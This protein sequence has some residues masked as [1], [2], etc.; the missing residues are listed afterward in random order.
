MCVVGRE[1]G[2]SELKNEITKNRPKGMVND[3]GG[4]RIPNRN[5]KK[6]LERI[7]IPL[8][9]LQTSLTIPPGIV[10]FYFTVFNKKNSKI[11]YYY[12]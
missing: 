8:Q 1:K 9:T 11:P 5:L 6:N 4:V 2:I 10:L 12:D 3:L 7:I